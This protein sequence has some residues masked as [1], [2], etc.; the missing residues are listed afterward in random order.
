MAH[1]RCNSL[2]SYGRLL[3]ACLWALVISSGMALVASNQA[4]APHTKVSLIAE[5]SAL[6]P[7]QDTWLGIQFRLEP[8]WHVYWLNPG[9]SGEPPRVTWK[10][11]AGFKA[12]DIQ[13]P[14]PERILAPSVTDYGYNQSVLLMA[15]M[16][17]PDGFTERT[18][19][20]DSEVRW[21][22]CRELCLPEQAKLRLTLPVSASAS[23]N[24]ETQELFAV[25][26]SRWP[27]PIPPGWKLSAWAGHDSFLLNIAA[28]HAETHAD[29]FPLSPG[30]DRQPHAAGGSQHTA[31]R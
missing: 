8:G 3:I 15:S 16:R 1:P 24:P 29:F 4:T 25:A 22:V 12:G 9:D 31:G 28:A 19:N 7:G 6:A 21:L 17:A 27:K 2:S 13:W 20:L 10:L 5:Q 30:Q 26:R 18:A 23:P 11:P 14:V